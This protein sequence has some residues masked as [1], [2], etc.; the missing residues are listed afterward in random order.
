MC[1]C[2]CV[3]GGGGGTGTAHTYTIPPREFLPPPG[4][5]RT[6]ETRIYSPLC[7]GM[8]EGGCT[9]L[10]HGPTGRSYPY[11]VRLEPRGLG[12]IHRSV[13]AEGVH[14][15][16]IPPKG[17]SLSPHG[18]PTTRRFGCVNSHVS[19]TDCSICTI[20]PHG[21]LKARET[22]VYPTRREGGRD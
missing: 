10:H 17:A 6:E 1:R 13:G 2:V 15:P 19:E 21:R 7:V 9:H 22:R 8:G 14:P 20:P 4:S 3:W 5:S 18:Q 16:A 11:K 12:C